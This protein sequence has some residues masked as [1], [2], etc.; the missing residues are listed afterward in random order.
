MH[1]WKGETELGSMGENETGQQL[2]KSMAGKKFYT[3]KTPW[4]LFNYISPF[5]PDTVCLAGGW[6]APK[7]PPPP[8]LTSLKTFVRKFPVLNF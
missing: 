4:G 2:R 5:H 7:L 6:A 3:N 8:P 1:S